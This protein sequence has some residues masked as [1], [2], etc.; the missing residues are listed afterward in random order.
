MESEIQIPGYRIIRSIGS[1]GMGDVYLA[2]QNSLQRRVAIKVIRSNLIG[3][4]SVVQRFLKEGAIIAKLTHPN[5]IKVFDTG[6][7]EDQLYLAM[8]YLDGGTL[9]D[10]MAQG[11][12]LPKKLEIIRTLLDAL[13]YAHQQGIVHRDVKPHNILFYSQGMPVLSDFGIAKTLVSDTTNLTAT[14]T[15]VG[16]PRYM[17]PEQVRGEPIDHRVDI[18]AMGVLFYELL[19]EEAIYSAVTDPFALAVRHVSDPVPRLPEPFAAFQPVLNRM[20]AKNRDERFPDASSAID[21]LDQTAPDAGAISATTIRVVPRPEVGDL[22]APTAAMPVARSKRTTT[23]LAL[24]AVAGLIAAGSTAFF[25]MRP[26]PL[27]PPVAETGESL[28]RHAEITRVFLQATGLHDQGEF[29]ASLSALDEGLQRWPDA[30]SLI[31]LRRAVTISITERERAVAAQRARERRQAIDDV[32][33]RATAALEAEE[34]EG[35]LTILDAGLAD[36]PEADTLAELRE[37]AIQRRDEHIERE[38][39]AELERLAEIERQAELDRRR[40]AEELAEQ[41]RLATETAERERRAAAIENTITRVENHIAESDYD[42][43]LARLD[44]SLQEWPEA[45]TLITLR[46]QVARQRD[47]HLEQLRQA[48]EI[49]EQP[50]PDDQS[51]QIAALLE[52]ADEQFTAR[53]LTTPAGN[54]A[55]ETYLAILEIDSENPEAHA[56]LERIAQQYLNWGESNKRSGNYPRSLIFIE[57]GMDVLPEHTALAALRDEVTALQQQATRAPRPTPPVTTTPRPAPVE[58]PRE[59]PPPADP[60]RAAAPTASPDTAPPAAEPETPERRPP[61]VRTFGTF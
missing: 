49:A 20:M 22:D 31:D 39:Q 52:R 36:W 25:L 48:A 12:S 61:R 45:D 10:R 47:E 53:L 33:D 23:A 32:H 29:D 17:S 16:S 1:G 7:H 2:L 30:E 26:Q 58:P 59:S 4:T 11:L 5:I 60:P 13:G 21:A 43:A 18:Y 56:G 42:T 41:R 35:S 38:R 40:Q 55:H 14:A 8:E 19:I 44:D 37:L 27:D 34:F 46:A 51:T 6:I 28:Q 50:A 57:R 24:I 54:N 3:D 15:F 9:K